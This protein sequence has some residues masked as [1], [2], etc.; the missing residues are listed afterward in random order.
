MKK[1]YRKIKGRFI[2]AIP[3]EWIDKAMGISG[4]AT[5][6]AL[7][8]WYLGG[9]SRTEENIVVTSKRAKEFHISKRS[10]ARS[11]VE[12]EKAGLI[13]TKRGVG[14]APRVSILFDNKDKKL[15]TDIEQ[16]LDE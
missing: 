14:Q 11:L 1:Q 12:L 6:T 8:I 3:L 7:M 15:N 13:E 16:G 4:S 10:F 9:I 2:R 5:K